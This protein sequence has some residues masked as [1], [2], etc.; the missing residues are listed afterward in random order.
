MALKFRVD[1]ALKTLIFSHDVKLFFSSRAG[2][3]IEVMSW[4]QCITA[5]LYLSCNYDHF[6][7]SGRTIITVRPEDK[8]VDEG[9]RVDLRCEAK[10]DPSLELRYYWK[11]DDAVVTYNNKIQWFEGAKVLTIASIT[12]YEAGNYTCVAYTPDPKRSEDQA[13]ATIDIGGTNTELE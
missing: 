3:K 13:S 2:K 11:R 10:A 9:T 1:C 5:I 8:I 7:F 6:A 12:V 4:L